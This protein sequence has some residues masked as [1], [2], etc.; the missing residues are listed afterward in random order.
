MLSMQ[1]P[2]DFSVTS[3]Q[4]L[5]VEIVYFLTGWWAVHSSKVKLVSKRYNVHVDCVENADLTANAY[6]YLPSHSEAVKR[7]TQTRNGR[8]VAFEDKIVT[9]SHNFYFEGSVCSFVSIT[10]AR[11]R[12]R[13]YMPIFHAAK[14][15]G[16]LISP[17]DG[18]QP[19]GNHTPAGEYTF[20][21]WKG[22]FPGGSPT[23]LLASV[24]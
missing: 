17:G 9:F 7:A 15:Q 1:R 12:V 19:P 18:Q 10:A 22:K 20:F 5:V 21:P 11:W 23:S 8:L 6:H 4:P 16:W 3:W 2:S 13:K 24:Q 14:L